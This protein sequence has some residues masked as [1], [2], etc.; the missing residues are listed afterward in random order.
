MHV[1]AYT[2]KGF[3]LIEMLIALTIG[4][5]LLAS[6]YNFYLGQK[7][8]HAL[9]EQVAEMQQ[10]ARAGMELIVREIRMAGYN[11]TRTP[12]VG[13]VAAGA[14]SIRIT[15]DLN[16]DG[17]VADADED[18]T[19]SLYDSGGDGDLDIGRK[20]AGGT[21]QPVAE[22]IDSLNFVYTLADGSTTT[23]PATP[24]QV[25]MIKV[26]LTARTAKPDLDYPTNG[27]HRTYTLESVITPRNLAY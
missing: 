2:Q 23:A 13:I 14:N 27:G 26:T 18:I 16:G 22:N 4:S 20:P 15:M 10:N 21:N 5:L 1:S 9:R 24:S 19:Y 12:G 25:R 6:L 11:P 7:K 8:T 17:D 3:T